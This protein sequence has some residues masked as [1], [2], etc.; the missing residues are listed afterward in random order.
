MS[1]LK[2]QTDEDTLGGR[3]DRIIRHLGKSQVEFS[4]VFDISQNHVS[5]LVNNK[6]TPSG[7][8]LKAIS[9]RYSIDEKWLKTGKGEMLQK[10]MEDSIVGASSSVMVPLLGRIPA[11]FP[12]LSDEQPVQYISLPEAP[13][14]S[15]ALIV[16]GDSM[17]PVIQDGDHV[18]FIRNGHTIKSGDIVV[19][20]NEWGETMLKRYRERDGE[21][22]LTSDNPSYPTVKPNE[23]YKIMGKVIDVWRKM[24]I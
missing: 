9:M 14:D 22:F 13:R 11:G 2:S 21:Q 24:K 16:H 7:P 15:Y 3:L 8:L 4:K 23:N 1:R 12:D 18:L 5:D 17:A 20:N 10:D 6:R 19:V